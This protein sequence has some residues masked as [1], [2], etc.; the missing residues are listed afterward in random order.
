MAAR[1]AADGAG[2]GTR[3]DALAMA[4]I[5]HWS[6]AQIMPCQHVPRPEVTRGEPVRITCIPFGAS[7]RDVRLLYRQTL[8]TAPWQEAPMTWA[9]GACHATI[10]GEYTDSPYAILYYFEIACDGVSSFFPGLG[11]DVSSTPY[12]HIKTRN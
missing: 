4:R 9:G 3:Q 1:L 10:P 6:T 2:E 11:E 8:Q 5:L 7:R 12:F